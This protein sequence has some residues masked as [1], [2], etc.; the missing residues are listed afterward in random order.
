MSA[1]PFT[2]SADLITDP[3][4]STK[5]SPKSKRQCPSVYK[6]HSSSMISLSLMLRISSGKKKIKKI[7][8]SSPYFKTDEELLTAVTTF[9]SPAIHKPVMWVLC[10]AEEQNK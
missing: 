2:G 8:A 6:E 9:L 10:T 4:A 1:E 3:F 7:E 5:A